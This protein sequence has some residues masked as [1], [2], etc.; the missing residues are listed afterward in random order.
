MYAFHSLVPNLHQPPG[1]LVHLLEE[2]EWETK[3]ILYAM[4][5][6]PRSLWGYEDVARVHLSFS[7]TL[8]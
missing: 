3:E 5:R 2:K 6:I 4:D 8:L 7:G 1:N